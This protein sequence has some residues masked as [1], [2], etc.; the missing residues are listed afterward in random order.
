MSA[1]P[2]EAPCADSAR[3]FDQGS[4]P[5]PLAGVSCLTAVNPVLT[6]TRECVLSA[7]GGFLEPHTCEACDQAAEIARGSL[8]LQ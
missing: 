3:G 7:S 4:G 2:H 8:A 1:K 6:Q 5:R